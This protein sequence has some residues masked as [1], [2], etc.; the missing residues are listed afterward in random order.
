MTTR[1]RNAIIVL[2][3]RSTVETNARD[4]QPQDSRDRGMHDDTGRQDNIHPI[5][6]AYRNGTAVGMG[7]QRPV[8]WEYVAD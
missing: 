2:V 4:A 8:A 6:V 7:Y 3:G 5:W 1:R